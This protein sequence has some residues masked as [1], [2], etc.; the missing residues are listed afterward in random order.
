MSMKRVVNGLLYDTD[1]AVLV[2]EGLS[3][4]YG[5]NYAWHGDLYITPN[6][7]RWFLA[8]SGDPDSIFAGIPKNKGIVPV[9]TKFV[10]DMLEYVEENVFDILLEHYKTDLGIRDA[11]EVPIGTG[12]Y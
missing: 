2:V 11:D 1:T 10:L 6:S 12:I 7:R 9:D 5:G 4:N 8:G 3:R